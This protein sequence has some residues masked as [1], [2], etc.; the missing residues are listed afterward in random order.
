MCLKMADRDYIPDGTGGFQRAQGQESLL[1]EALFLLTAR[2]G[3]FAP[4]PELGSRLYL[5][6]REK[7]ALRESLARAYAQEAVEQLGLK[8]VDAEV[9]QDGDVL[10]ITVTLAGDNQVNAL[11]VLVS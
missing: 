8:V 6:T 11:E 2:R 3:A 4:M 1:Q 9:W 7:A 10:R 5:L